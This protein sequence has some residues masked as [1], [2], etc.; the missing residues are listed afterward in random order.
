MKVEDGIRFAGGALR[1]HGLRSGLST[2][3]VAVGI[4][5]VVVL[6]AL[7]EGARRYVMREF[8]TLGSNLVIVVPGKVETS[9]GP[10]IGGTPRDITLDDFEAM[11]L[12]V[13]QV[14]EAAP[15]TIGEESVRYGDRSRSVPILGTTA[16]FLTVRRLQMASGRFL[17]PGDP[18]RGGSEM[19]IGTRLARELFG[20]ENP[21]GQTVRMGSWRFRVVGVLDP[22]GVSL[23]FDLDDVALIPVKTCMSAFQRTSLFRILAEVRNEAE[24]PAASAAILKLFAERHRSEDV[25]VFTQETV[26][27]AFSAILNVLTLALAGIAS[28]SLAVAGVGI[29]NVMLVSV[30]ERR[31]EIGLLKALGVTRS[32][33]VGVF[34][35]EAAILSMFGGIAGLALA[36]LAIRIFRE[37]Y[38]AFPA[39]PPAWAVLAALGT[40]L[41]V[42]L[43]FGLWPAWRAS[44]LDPVEALARR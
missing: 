24:I 29:M 14:R 32:Q 30:T 25:T 3:G 4:A 5:A 10:P 12:R 2:A 9:G 8:E 39:A 1:G 43:V 41:G 16:E 28:V 19:V 17:A 34:L 37:I 36:A 11:R 23:G 6:T 15:L 18:E 21:L 35:A 7:G 13:R 31:A 40:A 26:L 42:G 27:S 33:V 38:P 20:P 22:R 44:K